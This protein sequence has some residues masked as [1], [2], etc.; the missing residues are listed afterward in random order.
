LSRSERAPAASLTVSVRMFSGEPGLRRFADQLIAVAVAVTWRH[1]IAGFTSP[2]KSPRVVALMAGAKRML[3]C[4]TNRKAPLTL[5]LLHKLID[6]VSSPQFTFFD[7]NSLLRFRLFILA[8]FY[9]F[10]RFGNFPVLRLR[11]FCILRIT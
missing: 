7:P 9:A 3:A 11:H 8:S 2:A 6:R 5:G 4:P 10:L 1:S